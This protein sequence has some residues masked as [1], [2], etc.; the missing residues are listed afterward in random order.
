MTLYPTLSGVS[1][2][3]K[4]GIVTALEKLLACVEEAIKA[5]D[6][7]PFLKDSPLKWLWINEMTRHDMILAMAF[8]QLDRLNKCVRGSKVL[9][10]HSRELA[11]VLAQGM[12][13]RKW[14]GDGKSK[15]SLSTSNFIRIVTQRTS[16]YKVLALFDQKISKRLQITGIQ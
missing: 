3:A 7:F 5:H 12:V 9:D 11:E 4:T 14:L 10:D 6:S 16:F 8:Q 1:P 2:F 15:M 13:P